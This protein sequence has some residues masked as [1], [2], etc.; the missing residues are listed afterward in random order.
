MAIRPRSILLLILAALLLLSGSFATAAPTDDDFEA[1]LEEVDELRE[2]GEFVR[3]ISRLDNLENDHPDHV[4]I[5]WRRAWAKVDLGMEQDHDS[6][7]DRL[8]EEGFADAERAL[9]LDDTNPGAHVS[10]AVAAGQ[11]GLISGTR[12]QVELSRKVKEHA[13]KA[14]ELDPDRAEAYHVLGRWNHEVAS[15][16]FAA[17]TVVRAVYGGLPDASYEEAVTHFERSIKLD[18]RV[19]DHLEIGRTYKELGETDQARAAFERALEL[20]V[21]FHSDEDYQEEAEELLAGL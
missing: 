13:E 17:R 20:P 12:R 14:I 15:L 21:E 11:M 8:F 7:R 5:Y 4:E 18:E 16:G 19:V 10:M 9:E 1:A 2:Q 6:E 3:A